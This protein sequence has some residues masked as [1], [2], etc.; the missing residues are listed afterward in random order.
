MA[1]GQMGTKSHPVFSSDPHTLATTVEHN[2]RSQG[3]GVFWYDGYYWLYREDRWVAMDE[4]EAC[5]ALWSELVGVYVQ[6]GETIKPLKPSVLLAKNTVRVLRSVTKREI[7][8]PYWEGDTRLNP[9]NCVAFRDKVVEVDTGTEVDQGPRWVSRNVVPLLWAN[10][11]EA[12]CPLWMEC[13]KEWAPRGE[14]AEWCELMARRFGYCLIQRRDMAKFF[15]DYGPPRSG[16]GTVD[17]VLKMLVQRPAYLGT[18]LNDLAGS[19]GLDGAE[20]A[21]VLVVSEVNRLR[22]R[23]GESVVRVVKNI[24]GQDAT[25]IN[26]KHAR[27]KRSRT[28]ECVPILVANE[29]PGLPD[30]KMGLTSKMV[31]FLFPNSHLGKE[32]LELVVKL[33]AEL[34]GIAR[35]A[36]EGARRLLEDRQWVLPESSKATLSQFQ[37]SS[38]LWEAF[39]NA[40]FLPNEAGFVSSE[41]VKAIWRD[42]KIRN[43]IKDDTGENYVVSRMVEH[44]TWNLKKA[45]NVEGTKR[46][47]RG[48]MV[49][50]AA[51]DDV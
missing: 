36:I 33:K 31:P 35:W 28:L 34:E 26:A 19:F 9:G 30:R 11:R 4:E 3:G 1:D 13:L 8:I 15:F 6:Q 29:M 50:R 47:V 48:L 22:D 24:V 46:G 25:T 21:S 37:T 18:D 38:S 43:R 51:D 41:R 32:D 39:L 5:D 12:E 23:D 20:L 40:R 44:S 16:K 2:L 10:C 49:K 7:P 14:E 42:Y 45:H 17:K 27:Q